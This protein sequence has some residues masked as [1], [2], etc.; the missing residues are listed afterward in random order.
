M[1]KS[2]M[3]R[4]ALGRVRSLGNRP[5][6]RVCYCTPNRQMVLSIQNVAMNELNALPHEEQ[7]S[8]LR[9]LYNTV[10]EKLREVTNRTD[11]GESLDDFDEEDTSAAMA[12]DDEIVAEAFEKAAL[13]YEEQGE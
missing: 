8:T 5:G 11:R 4:A 13:T 10:A 7:R 12:L 2:E 6:E 3:I 1:K 9:E